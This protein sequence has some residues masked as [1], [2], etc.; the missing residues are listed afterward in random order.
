[1]ERVDK[2]TP[3]AAAAD[4]WT[5]PQSKSKGVAALAHWLLGRIAREKPG[6]ITAAESE[7]HLLE[8]GG[9]VGFASA[10]WTG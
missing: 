7:N 3:P 4:V 10:G 1:M 8:V 6:P 2:V 9:A 5:L